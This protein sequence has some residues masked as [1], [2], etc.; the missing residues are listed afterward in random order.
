LQALE[1]DHPAGAT[2]PA[3][4]LPRFTVPTIRLA[5]MVTLPVQAHRRG[6]THR[7]V[8]VRGPALEHDLE[9]LGDR[10]LDLLVV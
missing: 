2:N 10:D 1:P 6:R 5:D 9:Q 8:Q 7:E 3:G 4:R